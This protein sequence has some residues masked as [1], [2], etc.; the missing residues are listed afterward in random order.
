MNER[1][2][3]I[4][5]SRIQALVMEKNCEC[6]LFNSENLNLVHIHA[7]NMNLILIGII[8]FHHHHT[9]ANGSVSHCFVRANPEKHNITKQKAKGEAERKVKS[10]NDKIESDI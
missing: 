9:H 7:R 5:K 3:K 10:E 4:T 2:R 8:F 6:S 1:K